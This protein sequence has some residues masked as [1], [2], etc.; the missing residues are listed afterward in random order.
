M[1]KQM[2]LFSAIVF[3]LFPVSLHTHGVNYKKINGGVGIEAK[4][5]GG[6]PIS[7]AETKIFSPEDKIKIFQEGYTDINGRFLFYPDKPGKWRVFISD[8]MGHGVSTSIDIKDIK[9]M[10]TGKTGNIPVPLYNKVLT[11]I[12]I[13]LGITGILFYIVA[14]KRQ[15]Q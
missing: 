13:I 10:K 5:D 6:E 4:Y 8:G 3:L 2:F 7:E 15:K 11:G 1:K 9:T 12:S 14:V